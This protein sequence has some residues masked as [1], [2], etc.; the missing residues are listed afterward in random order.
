M[1]PDPKDLSTVYAS[2]EELDANRPRRCGRSCAGP[3]SLTAMVAAI[4][5]FAVMAGV[6]TLAGYVAVGHHHAQS[7]IFT[8]ISLHIVGMYGLVLVAGD[9]IDRIGR[10]TAIVTG[11]LAMAA[12]NAGLAVLTRSQG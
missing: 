9:V 7:S 11:L 5:S 10:R 2:P 8:I 6:M 4:G 12:S 3:A 1:R